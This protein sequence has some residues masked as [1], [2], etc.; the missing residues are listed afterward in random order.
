M[1]W[2][3]GAVL[4]DVR[5]A[6]HQDHRLL[7][8]SV[9]GKRAG[10]LT[11]PRLSGGVTAS[12]AIETLQL[13]DGRISARIS[14]EGHLVLATLDTG[15]TRERLAQKIRNNTNQCEVN[16]WK[17]YERSSGGYERQI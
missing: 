17:T 5:E 6:G 16:T 10:A 7:Q 8:D 1:S 9:A 3:T 11:E 14:I 2:T 13:H 4:L 12:P 15:A